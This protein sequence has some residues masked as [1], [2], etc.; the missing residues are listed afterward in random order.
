MLN[1]KFPIEVIE[2][3]QYSLFMVIP[4][5][6]GYFTIITTLFITFPYLIFS[7]NGFVT[8]MAKYLYRKQ[9]RKFITQMEIK[10]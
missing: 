3:T 4:I 7:T 6:G 9:K 1:L 2:E 5:F 10:K 8:H